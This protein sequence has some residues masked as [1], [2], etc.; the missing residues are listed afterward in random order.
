MKVV[1][2]LAL[3]LIFFLPAETHAG[4]FLVEKKFDKLGREVISADAIRSG[5]YSV[6]FTERDYYNSLPEK[7]AQELRDSIGYLMTE[8]DGRIYPK[9]R[10][11]FG[12]ERSPGPDG[13]TKIHIVLQQMK[14]GL[15]GYV[16]EDD[17]DIG[18][19][20]YINI[21]DVNNRA[22]APS[23][24]AHEFQ[25]LITLNQKNIL[26]GAKEEQ[27]LNEARSEYAPTLLGYN[28]VYKGSYLEKRVNE[29][30]AHPSDAL[31]D[32]RGKSTDHAAVNLFMNYLI[33]SFGEDLLRSMTES[34]LA[35][36]SSVSAALGELGYLADFPDIF[37]D[38]AAAVY[39]NSELAGDG[40]EKFRY[41]NKNLSLANVRVLPTTT[42]RIYD[43]NSSGASFVIDNW[44]AQWHR[45]VPGA[46][47]ED[48]TLHIR[49]TAQDR[50][51]LR[52]RSIVSD[53]FGRS[54]V[55]D[56]DLGSSS[57]FSVENFGREVSSVVLVPVYAKMGS[58][59]DSLSTG[60][61]LEGFISNTFASRFA[62]G[63][64]VRAKGDPKVY[65]IKNS[66]KI[67][68]VFTRWIQTPEVFNFYQHFT[69]SD[70]IEVKPELLAGF[71][72]S[73]LIRRAGDYKIYAVDR[74][75]R[76]KWLDITEAEFEA[77]GY[78]WN[79]VYEVNE[80]EFAWF[81]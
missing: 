75:G 71:N 21:S 4:N 74:F 49:V 62:E 53:F 70:I 34:A 6:F 9:L 28:D 33:D 30:L 77:A 36:V 24:L 25:H 2:L 57:V 72:E 68:E 48:T 65:I 14:D 39:I 45:F 7:D 60:Y 54:Q 51:G 37:S 23:Y 27:W 35:G 63:T 3:S 19:I 56:F 13:D 80:T 38:W 50:E 79:A 17:I 12:R 15:G 31:L 43:N 47:G 67:G 42:F 10:D 41:K 32:W 44:S 58:A 76:K 29:F 59:N 8:F 55:R 46:V 18:E 78:N 20:I 73:F 64:L 26:R 5:I 22:F 69:W 81:R 1:S 66:P 61:S 40:T 16:R 11:V 52:M